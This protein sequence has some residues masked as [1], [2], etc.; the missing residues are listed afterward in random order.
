[1]FRNRW[2]RRGMSIGIVAA[3]LPMATTGCFGEFRLTRKV[4]AFNK[5]VSKDKW[6]R[7]LVFLVIVIVP[8][9]HLATF[10]DALIANSIEFWT[11]KNPISAS[12]GA[13]RVVTAPGGEVLTMRLREDGAIDATVLYGNGALESFTLRREADAVIAYDAE[14]RELAR[15]GDVLG[16]P[17]LL[18]AR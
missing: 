17:A 14:G 3:F 11:G 1:M 5:S 8:V 7:W 2:L 18:A 15:V 6:V 4:Y 9:Y 13:T 16:E 12:A 10:I